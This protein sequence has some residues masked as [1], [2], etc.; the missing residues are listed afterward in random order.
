MQTEPTIEATKQLQLIPGIGKSLS[1]D[2]VDLGYRKVNELGN[3]P[4][5]RWGLFI[6]DTLFLALIIST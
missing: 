2:L 3:Y 5:N 6:P 1:R 4:A